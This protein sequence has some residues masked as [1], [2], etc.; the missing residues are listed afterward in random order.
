M[1]VKLQV[2]GQT[3]PPDCRDGAIVRRMRRNGKGLGGVWAAGDCGRGARTDG[4]C[5]KP[6]QSRAGRPRLGWG[7]DWQ[8]RL[9]RS[10][11]QA[12]EPRFVSP[13]GRGA[14]QPSRPS[15]D[16]APAPACAAA[17]APPNG[18]APRLGLCL[19]SCLGRCPAPRLGQC[20]SVLPW[21]MPSWTRPALH[22]F[23]FASISVVI[24]S[25]S[26]LFSNS[27]RGGSPPP[28]GTMRSHS[29]RAQ[30]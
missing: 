23:K 9:R 3:K 13:L 5:P 14:P 17:R 11:P 7:R 29:A 21:A 4:D 25:A 10:A 2:R 30:A 27:E 20:P 28:P 1:S 15:P 8:R 22:L 19:R 6:A 24:A 18:P 26:C 16:Q 12:A